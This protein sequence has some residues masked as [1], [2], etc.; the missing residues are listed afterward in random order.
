MKSSIVDERREAESDLS[1]VSSDR[2]FFHPTETVI[3]KIICLQ[4]KKSIWSTKDHEGNQKTY[5]YL[6]RTQTVYVDWCEKRISHFFP[7]IIRKRR[8]DRK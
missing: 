2:D 6:K 7:R 4:R 8:R 3:K 5:L 1:F